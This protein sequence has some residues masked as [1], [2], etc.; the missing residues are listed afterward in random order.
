MKEPSVDHTQST[1]AS[2]GTANTPQMVTGSGG[3]VGEERTRRQQQQQHE[4]G[5]RAAS[6]GGGNGE[7]GGGYW[8]VKN[9]ERWAGTEKPRRCVRVRLRMALVANNA[10]ALVGQAQQGL[11]LRLGG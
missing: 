1:A 9:G 3:S 5:A 7:E 11:A 4:A 10:A 6:G 2:G 8:V